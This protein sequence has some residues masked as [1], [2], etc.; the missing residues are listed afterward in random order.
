MPEASGG[1]SLDR[2]RPGAL[3]PDDAAGW[4]WHPR[5]RV[6][7]VDDEP[8]DLDDPPVIELRMVR[9]DQYAVSRGKLLIRRLHGFQDGAAE[10]HRGDVGVRIRN[11]SPLVSELPEYL[12][13]RRLTRVSDAALVGDPE[14]EDP[15]AVQAAAGLVQGLGRQLDDIIGHGPVEL[16]GQMDE[17]RLVPVQTHLPG[18]VV[19]I[20]G[21]AM[22]PDA[23]TR[24]EGEEAEWLRGCGV[25][26]SEERR[27]GKE[28][29]SRWSPYH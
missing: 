8:G 29:R 7:G 21:D 28:G 1:K 17:T 3:Q 19:G 20:D 22:A 5:G 16:V 15:G 2:C 6:S 18:E 14:R 27:V 26:R 12:Q 13:G 25:V 9:E 24:V 23:G 10:G 4:G 11:V